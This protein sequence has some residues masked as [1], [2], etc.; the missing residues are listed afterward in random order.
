MAIGA[1]MNPEV[2]LTTSTDAEI[3]GLLL[4]K[5]YQRRRERLIGLTSR[6]FDG[7]VN[8]HQIQVIAAQLAD[9][10][11]IHWRANRGRSGVGGGMG[12]ITAA[13]VDVVEGRT[14]APVPMQLPQH[15]GRF[16]ALPTA[17][18]PDPASC[19]TISVA[20]DLLLQSIEY[21]AASAAD[22]SAA[23]VLLHAFRQ[24]PLL[25]TMAASHAEQINDGAPTAEPAP[26]G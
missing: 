21:S 6:D 20:I 15:S 25:R 3:R 17:A 8:E 13:G 19:T 23:T 12:T 14:N 5:Y 26:P 22:K 2:S 7:A 1:A 11:L 4:Q 9:H 10:G 16:D 18:T 24:H